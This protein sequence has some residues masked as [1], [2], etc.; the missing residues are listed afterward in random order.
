MDM[1]LSELRELVMDKEAWHAV[2]HGVAKSRTWLSNWTEGMDTTK[3][4]NWRNGYQ[5]IEFVEL[6]FL[7]RLI[8]FF[9][10]VNIELIF[11][12]IEESIYYIKSDMNHVCRLCLGV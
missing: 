1:S 6:L 3:Q 8:I 11:L 9:K 5:H 4:L 7:E 2:I 10:Y 12:I